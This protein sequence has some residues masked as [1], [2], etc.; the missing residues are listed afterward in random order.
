MRT[1]TLL[2]VLVLILC[3]VGSAEAGK[4]EG[5]ALIVHTN[6]AMGW[7]DPWG[8]CDF[9]DEWNPGTCEEANPQTDK[10]GFFHSLIW[11]IAALPEESN[12]AATAC[13]FGLD[14]NLPADY[15]HFGAWIYCGPVGTYESAGSD[16]PLDAATAANCVYFGSPIGGNR[17]FPVYYFIVTGGDVE[18]AYF[19]SAV[20]PDYGTAFFLDDSA[21]HVE[22]EIRKFGQVRWGEPGYNECPDPPVATVQTTWGRIRT[23]YR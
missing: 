13:C 4:N 2:M 6:D 15:N 3:C 9:W 19:G 17:F 21:P 20:N 8:Q 16:W 12:P 7:R 1:S 10:E 11:F 23:Q 22:D 18:G 14:H 5:G